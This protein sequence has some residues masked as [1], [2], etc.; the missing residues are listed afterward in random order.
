MIAT[1]II[2]PRF[3]IYLLL[4]FIR[5]IFLAPYTLLRKGFQLPLD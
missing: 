5:R 1:C 3:I 4:I 2:T